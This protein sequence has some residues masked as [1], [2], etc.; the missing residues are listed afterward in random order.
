MGD[1]SA[2]GDLN[3]TA[4]SLQSAGNITAGGKATIKAAALA[5]AGN[6]NVAGSLNI[7]NGLPA[8]SQIGSF[9][10]GSLAAISKS[11]WIGSK[12]IKGSVIGPIEIG[13]IAK[14]KGLYQFAF[15]QFTGT[16][17]AVIGGKS[18]NAKTGAGLSLNGAKLILTPGL[19][20]TSVSKT[21]VK[22]AVKA[23]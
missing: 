20:A 12:S 9:K 1:I 21:T 2:P 23:K 19:T 8:L 6:L 15:S 13:S 4:N 3:L 14:G 16:P 11:L 17:N 7:G 10:A 22:S 5:T 18:G